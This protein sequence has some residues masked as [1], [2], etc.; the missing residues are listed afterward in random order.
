MYVKVVKQAASKDVGPPVHNFGELWSN[1]ATFCTLLF[2]L[3]GEGC[4]LYR[5]MLQIL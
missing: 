2:I 5:S 3:F 1:I 4:D